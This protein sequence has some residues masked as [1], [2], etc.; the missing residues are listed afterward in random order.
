[1]SLLRAKLTAIV[2]RKFFLLFTRTGRLSY[3]IRELDMNTIG[4]NDYAFEYCDVWGK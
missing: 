2:S 3:Y 1:M 4:S